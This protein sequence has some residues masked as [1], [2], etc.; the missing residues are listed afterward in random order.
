MHEQR[1]FK[2]DL[3]LVPTEKRLAHG[4][5]EGWREEGESS[6]AVSACIGS[7]PSPLLSLPSSPSFCGGICSSARV[8]AESSAA[9][10]YER[11]LSQSPN[12]IL[13]IV[14]L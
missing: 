7:A 5:E 9:A 4:R 14:P 12:T 1:D 2:Y 6:A 10:V 8:C 13:V 11:V 3:S